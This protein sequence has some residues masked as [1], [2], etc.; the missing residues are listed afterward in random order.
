VDRGSVPEW[1]TKLRSPPFRKPY[2]DLVSEGEV[3]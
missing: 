1:N 2:R 3:S